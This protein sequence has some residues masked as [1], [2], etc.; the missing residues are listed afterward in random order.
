MFLVARR[1]VM[2]LTQGHDSNYQGHSR[3]ALKFLVWAI[4]SYRVIVILSYL[5]QMFLVARGYVMTLTQG[6]NSKVNVRVD[7]H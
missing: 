2:T 3:H 6:H 7:M 5:E 4:F 1:C